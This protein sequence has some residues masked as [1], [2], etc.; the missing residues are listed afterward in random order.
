MFSLNDGLVLITKKAVY[1]V[2]LSDQIDPKRENPNL[3]PNVQRRILEMGTDSEL[4][5]RILL[6]A[7][8]LFRK[9]FLPSFIDI[10]QP[11]SLSFEVLIDMV[12][13]H[14]TVTEYELVE[15]KEI[16]VAEDR[17]QKDGSFGIPSISDIK[18][19]CKAL[20]QKA[21]HVEQTIR[22]I[23]RLFYP[24]IRTKDNFDDLHHFIKRKYG[25]DDDF[26]EFIGQALP[27][28]K[29]VR[30]TTRLFRSQKC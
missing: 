8:E 7:K 22:D 6:T 16:A 5:G 13:M 26:A 3:P 21:D 4:I 20:F 29:M 25:N 15:K 14:A 11:T 30:N 18:T 27:F 17:E 24:E 1:E 23:I 28:L 9:E 19:R 10:E 2:K 12:A